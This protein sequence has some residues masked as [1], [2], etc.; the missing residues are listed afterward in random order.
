MS[1]SSNLVLLLSSIV[2][3]VLSE[4]EAEV[5]FDQL[6]KELISAIVS[7]EKEIIESVVVKQENKKT[8]KR[9]KDPNKPKRPE[10]SFLL[11]SKNQR[12]KLKESNKNMESKEIMKE[13]GRMWKSLSDEEK[14]SF[15][16][17][18]ND[19][20]Q[21]YKEQVEEYNKN[22]NIVK[23]KKVAKKEIKKTS[24]YDLFKKGKVEEIRKENPKIKIKDIEE[25]I[26]KEWK[27]IK[28]SDY[29]EDKLFL[30]ELKQQVKLNNEKVVNKSGKKIVKLIPFNIF[31]QKKVMKEKISDP[32]V[33]VKDLLPQIKHEWE[34]LR[35]NKK[36]YQQFVEYVKKLSEKENNE[37]DT[38]VE[39]EYEGEED[40][41]EKEEE[42]HEEEHEKEHEEE[43]NGKTLLDHMND[44][45]DIYDKDVLTKT[46]LKEELNKRN[47]KFTKEEFKDALNEIRH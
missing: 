34:L 4:A 40:E 9:E 2:K 37:D 42:E 16:A 29:E 30:E 33:K 32:K 46:L 20:K 3:E 26:K 41:S 1:S 18:S 19:K 47:V 36:K 21:K 23:E 15:D 10:S 14:E 22:N 7:K 12:Q 25:D 8:K 43:K 27:R 28:S 39:E 24:P 6:E 44:I 17:I 31:K 38:E 13:L 35:S 5:D 45:F 11:W